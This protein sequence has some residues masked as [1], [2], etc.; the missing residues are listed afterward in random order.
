MIDRAIQGKSIYPET[1]L[2]TNTAHATM[3][4]ERKEHK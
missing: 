4:A 3:P 2:I 1:E